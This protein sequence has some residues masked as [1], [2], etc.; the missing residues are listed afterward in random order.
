M[1][2]HSFDATSFVLGLLISGV[3]LIYLTAEVTDRTVDGAWVFPVVLIGLGLAAVLAGLTRAFRRDRPEPI[4]V[5]DP[6]EPASSE[7]STWES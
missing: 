2:K 1:R 5:A 6:A 3:A 7:G 4:P